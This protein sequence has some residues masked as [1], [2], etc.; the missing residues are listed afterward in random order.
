MKKFFSF[1]LAGAMSL[2]VM[3]DSVQLIKVT[4]DGIPGIDEP[5]LM[6]MGISPDGSYICGTLDGFGI[7]IANRQTGEVKYKLIEVENED[8]Q[9]RHVSN[10][11]LGV[12]V[13]D[14]GIIYSFNTDEFTLIDPP[15]DARYVLAE[16]ITSTGDFMV[17]T[18]VGLLSGGTIGAY[19]ETG[20]T[21]TRLPMPGK[22][23]MAGLEKLLEFGTAAKFVSDDRKVIV[24]HVGSFGL[25]IAWRMNDKGEYELDTLFLKYMKRTASDIDNPDKPLMAVS[26]MYYC[27]SSN[28]RYVA[29]LGFIPTGYEDETLSVPVVYDMMEKQLK[30]YDEEQFYGEFSGALYPR[31]IT[32]DGT[33]IG[34]VG[35]PNF[36]SEGAF[37]MKAGE[38]QAQL[39]R[40][41]FPAFDSIFGEGDSLGFS[42][43][44]AISADG[45]YITGFV[46]Y[47]EDYFD[48]Y[49]PAYYQS[50]IIDTLGDASAVET[51]S[52]GFSIPQT[53]S[54][55]SIDGRRLDRLTDGINIV[56]SSDGTV[57]KVLKK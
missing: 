3:A 50:F 28:G 36:S 39:F 22:E 11:G 55:Y 17:G 27:M 8:A 14:D 2:P 18:L 26:A 16:D 53:E 15:S 38:T 23:D 21:W 40:D 57:R 41:V 12:G 47:S 9:L 44:A 52:S 54:V 4:P 48:S 33:F 10:T 31:S 24:G 32:D 29:A 20:E 42:I 46:Y 56:R 13:A 34:T 6:S 49:T 37:I 7:F 35:M 1:L 30:I 25:P 51:V 43:P 19:S 5:M 45:R